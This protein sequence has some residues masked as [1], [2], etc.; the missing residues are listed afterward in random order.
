MYD[1]ISQMDLEQQQSPPP[2]KTVAG[3]PALFGSAQQQQQYYNN[4]NERGTRTM[5][6]LGADM[7]NVTNLQTPL[8][9]FSK[10]QQ[11]SS[12]SSPYNYQPASRSPEQI[13]QEK[14]RLGYHD[15]HA[16]VSGVKKNLDKHAEHYKGTDLTVSHLDVKKKSKGRSSLG[17]DMGSKLYTSNWNHD[18]DDKTIARNKA[19]MGLENQQSSNLALDPNSKF[20]DYATFRTGPGFMSLAVPASANGLRRQFDGHKNESTMQDLLHDGHHAH[21]DFG[22]G[23]TMEEEE[24]RQQM[25]GYV[26]FGLQATKGYRSSSPSSKQDQMRSK[27]AGS[28]QNVFGQGAQPGTTGATQ[29]SA[30]NKNPSNSNNNLGPGSKTSQPFNNPL[31]DLSATL[32]MINVYNAEVRIYHYTQ[33]HGMS[34]HVLLRHCNALAD[35]LKKDAQLEVSL[36]KTRTVEELVRWL[37]ATECHLLLGFYLHPEFDKEHMFDHFSSVENPDDPAAHLNPEIAHELAQMEHVV[38]RKRSILTDKLLS[39]S[40][41][42]NKQRS[43]ENNRQKHLQAATLHKPVDELIPDEHPM[44]EMAMLMRKLGAP[45]A[46]I[47]LE[48]RKPT[49]PFHD[50]HRK[51]HA[52]GLRMVEQAKLYGGMSYAGGRTADRGDLKAAAHFDDDA[53]GERV[54]SEMEYGLGHLKKHEFHYDTDAAGQ[55]HEEF[56]LGHHI[57]FVDNYAVTHDKSAAGVATERLSEKLIQFGSAHHQDKNCTQKLRVHSPLRHSHFQ[58]SDVVHRVEISP[59]EYRVE[60]RQKF[61]LSRRHYDQEYKDAFTTTPK[62]D[63]GFQPGHKQRRHISPLRT[64]GLNGEMFSADGRSNQIVYVGTNYSNQVQRSQPNQVVPPTSSSAAAAAGYSKFL[65]PY[66]VCTTPPP[67]SHFSCKIPN[68]SASLVSLL[69]MTDSGSPARTTL[70]LHEFFVMHRLHVCWCLYCCACNTNEREGELCT[71]IHHGRLCPK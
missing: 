18:W 24:Q 66:E 52:D 4:Y 23:N 46:M 13:L 2:S 21:I 33:L 39:S 62:G 16:P 35:S 58:G 5:S 14:L 42:V 7:E 19:M 15:R 3:K 53:A 56:G 32:Q 40:D 67:H 31:V 36:P 17:M 45:N 26:N 8:Q 37:V 29:I 69:C 64:D 68:P 48:L 43:S 38:A 25:A 44:K 10:H 71:L 47:A 27:Y 55:R 54:K 51:L 30:N 9:D 28:G 11:P 50:H 59:G 34:L 41:A 12:T 22:T 6:S 49:K 65:P 60:D 20:D 1:R 61:G 57:H 70:E 63:G